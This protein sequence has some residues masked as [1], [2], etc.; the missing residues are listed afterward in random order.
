LDRK[1]LHDWLGSS[2]LASAF[3]GFMY[4]EFK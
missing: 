3:K 1:Q 2:G 4:E